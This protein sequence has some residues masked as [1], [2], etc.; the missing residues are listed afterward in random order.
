MSDYLRVTDLHIKREK[1]G[2]G[3]QI[4]LLHLQK[5]NTLDAY[6]LRRS[7]CEELKNSNLNG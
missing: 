6:C 2:E 3:W 7:S 4:A 1:G 5:R